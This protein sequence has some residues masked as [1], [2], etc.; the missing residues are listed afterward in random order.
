[1][2][3]GRS[4]VV[5]VCIVDPEYS[6]LGERLAVTINVSSLQL[7]KADEFVDFSCFVIQDLK[8]ERSDGLSKSREIG[9]RRLFV[10]GLKVVKEVGEFSMSN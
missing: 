1:M 3:D 10:D 8:E 6:G 4:V 9:I 5:Y 7:N 2:D